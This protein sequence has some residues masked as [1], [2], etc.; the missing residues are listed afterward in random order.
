[1]RH[2]RWFV[3]LLALVAL[4]VASSSCV[5][6]SIPLP[7]P[8]LLLQIEVPSDGQLA[9]SNEASTPVEPGTHVQLFNY[10][11]GLGV[12]TSADAAG[13]FA[14]ELA[15][16]LGDMLQLGFSADGFNVSGG[17]FAAAPSV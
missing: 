8:P 11:T 3:C 10:A 12:I 15:G 14:L 13:L 17:C 4:S 5:T 7:I 16:E 1:M 6:P 9:I 2:P